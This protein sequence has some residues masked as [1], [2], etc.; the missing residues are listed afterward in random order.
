MTDPPHATP[1]APEA[2]GFLWGVSTSAYQ[3]EGGYNG[4]GQPQ[5]NWANAEASRHVMPSGRAVD[6]W[7]RFEEDFA[8]CR[9]MGLNSFR[10]GIEWSRVQPSSSRVK[11]PPPPFDRNALDHYVH[12]IAACRREGLEPIVTLHHFVHPAWLGPDAWLDDATVGLFE[13]YV[14]TV[15]DHVNTR[16]T[17]TFGQRPL[18]YYITI[19]EPN[20]LGLNTY[21][22]H[23]FPAGGARG[24][25]PTLAAWNNLLVA[26]VRA[27]NAIHDFHRRLGWPAPRVSLN[28]YCT[29]LYWS[30]KLLLDL[31]H[32]R[33][34]GVTREGLR[35]HI[36]A[37][38]ADFERAY[39]AAGIP[40]KNDLLYRIG[41]LLRTMLERLGTRRF[42]PDAFRRFLDELDRS[43]RASVMDFVA[44]DY[45]DPFTAHVLRLPSLQPQE[46]KSRSFR[47]WVMHS[48]TVEWWDWR[49]LPRGLRFFCDYYS[50]EFALP[51]L[52][53]ENGMALRKRRDNRHI[54]R[55]DRIYRSEFI[56]LHV[57][58]V[59]RLVNEG[60]PVMGYLHW[61]LFDNYEWGSYT[62]RFGLFSIDYTRGSDRLPE[63]HLGDRPG[64]TYA[65]LVRS[66]RRRMAPPI[67]GDS[68]GAGR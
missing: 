18:R 66:A 36:L 25:A 2:E 56:T 17:E 9:R 22:T 15:V 62:P 61:S 46:M 51:V 4:S 12:M 60:I 63:D 6:F 32:V 48:V 34:H 52:I 13:T 3:A 20:L 29:D 41:D 23:Q 50:R 24:L 8:L 35:E 16:L 42:R 68:A 67:P 31:L 39:R 53:A 14:K 43:P 30:D 26:H 21:L 44:L 7:T 45:Y 27:Y 33:R 58:E 5:T 65:E 40:L 37:R 64:D 49:V 28:N 1:R 54:P 47:A 11:S 19:N 38:A 10:L 59:V 57:G 55:R